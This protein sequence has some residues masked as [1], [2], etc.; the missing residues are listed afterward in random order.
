M[1][2]GG[3]LDIILEMG[4]FMGFF[5]FFKRSLLVKA[6]PEA[7]CTGPPI[8]HVPEEWIIFHSASSK[9]RVPSEHPWTKT[10]RDGFWN[11]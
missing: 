11:S 3:T 9:T 10:Y 4:Y 5:F 1:V 7:A 8:S 6:T 2:I